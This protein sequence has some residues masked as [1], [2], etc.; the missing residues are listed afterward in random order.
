MKQLKDKEE[1]VCIATKICLIDG[2]EF[3]KGMKC[4]HMCFSI[5]SK[6]SKEDVEEVPI[7]VVDMLGEFFDIVSD[8]VLIPNEED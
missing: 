7:E 2:K 4:E 6:D 5:I 8:N 3:L 1:R